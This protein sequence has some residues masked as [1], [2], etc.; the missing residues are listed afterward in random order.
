MEL[1][2]PKWALRYGFFQMP[3]DKNGFTGDD[4]FLMSLR[5]LA[6]AL[7]PVFA[8]LGNDDGI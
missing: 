3:R 7:W 6:G 5:T 1:N 4:Q 8:L 2:Q